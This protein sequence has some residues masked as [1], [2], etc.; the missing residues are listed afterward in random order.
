MELAAIGFI[1]SFI[2]VRIAEVLVWL[3][4][5]IVSRGCEFYN[6]SDLLAFTICS[7]AFILF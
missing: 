1:F 3:A 7:H 5:V 2:V 4:C 6:V